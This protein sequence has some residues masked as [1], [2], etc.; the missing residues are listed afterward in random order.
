MA[1][2]GGLSLIAHALR[3]PLVIAY[4]ATGILI[5]PVLIGL[6]HHTIEALAQIGVALLLF[7]VGLGL[8]PSVLKRIGRTAFIT[9]T[10]QMVFVGLLGY[11][12]TR[13]LGYSAVAAMYI[14][15]ALTF[16]STIIVVHMLS[17]RGAMEKLHGAISIGILIVQDIAAVFLLMAS[18]SLERSGFGTND[19]LLLAVRGG[20]L[21]FSL[22]VIAV[23]VMPKVA[24]YAARSRELLFILSLGWLFI[25]AG[26]FSAAG[27]S[28]EV[29]ALL[30]GVTL[31]LSQY[32]FE[33]SAR[34]RSIRDFF[35]ILFFVLLGL[36]VQLD[37]VAEVIGAT[38]LVSAFV[39][40][41]K[42]FIFMLALGLLGYTKR[43]LFLVGIGLAQISEFSFILM[44]RA[45]G[46]NIVSEQTLTL[47]T[48]VG[49]IT[50]TVS[51][52]MTHYSE[53]LYKFM[54]PVLWIFEHKGHRKKQE[55]APDLEEIEPD[56]LL[57]GHNRIGYAILDSLAKTRPRM[58]ALVVDY[59]PQTIARLRAKGEYARYGDATDQELLRELPWKNVKMIISTIPSEEVNTL[60]THA[61]RRHKRSA[62][63]IVTSHDIDEA[64]RLYERGAAFVIMPHFLGGHFMVDLLSD[65][66]RDSKVLTKRR[67]EAVKELRARKGSGHQLPIITV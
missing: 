14:A 57:F 66:R 18:S 42:P 29:G 33:I 54:Q 59:D 22:I 41:F 60:I 21:L 40:L 61:V 44:S 13:M 4:I 45:V 28:I 49:I 35:I 11:G 47:M 7:I 32:R 23:Y 3:Q 63:V 43:T 19:L 58:R 37:M 6:D 2:A 25:V 50:I 24:R 10:V 9:A 46:S 8:S 15:A 30:A 65:V 31:S 20:L 64:L 1:M 67:R 5:S 48:L 39:L 12:L 53:Q 51:M 16:S 52:Y 62:R 26:A 27:F 36:S 17:E 34:L 56:I 55:D 38:L